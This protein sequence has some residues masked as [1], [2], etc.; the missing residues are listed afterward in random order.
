MN[1]L[2]I[3]KRVFSS[4]TFGR[5][6][7]SSSEHFVGVCKRELEG[8]SDGY[9]QKGELAFFSLQKGF[10]ES[11]LLSISR[12]NLASEKPASGTRCLR[13]VVRVNQPMGRNSSNTYCLLISGID[14]TSEMDPSNLLVVRSTRNATSWL[15]FRSSL[16]SS[17]SRLQRWQS[18]RAMSSARA[19]TPTG[20]YSPGH[21]DVP[22]SL[23]TDRV[24]L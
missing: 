19:A 5:Q 2:S 12:E 21:L 23:C 11:L 24:K 9:K 18:K 17:W 4:L 15:L 20:K 3:S 14:M 1:L 6:F 7:L 13:K 16:F 22:A 10:S 8:V